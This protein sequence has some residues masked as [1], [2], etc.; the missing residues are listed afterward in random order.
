MNANDPTATSP[1]RGAQKPPPNV[2]TLTITKSQHPCMYLRAGNFPA[3]TRP[4]CVRNARFESK[5]PYKEQ[6]TSLP[7][8]FSPFAGALAF[9]L[10]ISPRTRLRHPLFGKS[11]ICTLSSFPVQIV[12]FNGI[13]NVI[14]MEHTQDSGDF[15][16]KGMFNYVL[17]R[18]ALLKRIAEITSCSSRI[19]T[20]SYL[21]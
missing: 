7:V 9:F 16:R 4:K 18:Q 6:G 17:R 2:C 11:F 20:P 10:T 15:G 12:T 5:E 14:S 19:L 3:Q 13:S 8:P 21:T 1:Q